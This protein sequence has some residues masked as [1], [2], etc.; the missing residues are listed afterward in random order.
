MKDL[1][2]IIRYTKSLWR[3][4]TIISFFVVVTALLGL[5]SPF[6]T[7]GIV[8][9]I[10]ANL[11]GQPAN[12]KVLIIFVLLMLAS[13]L[14][15]TVLS[16]INGYYGD[17]MSARINSL[18]SERY[19]KHLLDLPI[20]YYDNEL[21]GKITARLERSINTIANLMQA[22]A[23]NFSQTV[24]TV[25]F[26]LVVIAFYSW[27]VAILL[28]I[29]FPIYIWLTRK[30]SIVWQKQQK[31][32]NKDVDVANGRFIESVSQIR[33]VKSFA[34]ELRELKFFTGKRQSIEQKTK[35]QSKRWH[36]YDTARRTALSVI[37][38][39]IYGII[40]YQAYTKQISIGTMTL[41]IQLT[42]QAQFPLF[43]MSFLI[44]NLQRAIADS[45]DYFAVMAVEPEI[46]D[47]ANANHLQVKRGD[48]EYKNLDFSYKAGQKILTN[49][50]LNV[51]PG[52]KLALVGESG[53]G[54]TTIANL[55]LR[56]YEP[57]EGS[58]L[59]DGQD[60]SQVSQKSL[61]EAIGVV[62]QD[63]AL[64]SGTVRDNIVYSKPKASSD[65]MK[66]AA[67]AANAHDFIMKLPKGYDT[68]IGERG[69]KLSGGQKQRIA[70]AR[71]ILKNSPIL[72]LDE[73]TS[74]LDSKAERDV[75][76]ALDH[77]MEGRT[78]III[79][80]R[81]ST[82][83]AVDKIAAI[84]GGK[85]VEFGSPAELAHKPNGVY[86]ELL[87]LQSDANNRALL[88]KYQLAKN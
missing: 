55:L 12:V 86:A 72:I 48:I 87:Q 51:A 16:N 10:V 13:S 53:E 9:G 14:L 82:I 27:P 40:F 39:A 41:L 84:S 46:V 56:F 25:L 50:N 23:N 69:V 67:Q 47:I 24:L 15:T 59:I 58:I 6:L 88:S 33:V 26:T 71:A 54:K 49:I 19:Y 57:S 64:F 7:K 80:H 20:S 75:Q 81:L 85:I 18:L 11:T 76:E 79:A 66:Q 37:F 52:S 65:Q 60:I 5:V 2:K 31:G 77:L 4:Y 44:D 73:A 17:R 8:D 30:S 74:S 61:R 22:F 63:P 1:L 42:T 45:R 21:T 3:Y 34:T 43:G 68:E 38:F 83:A 35:V 78:T 36:W 29:L 70:I 32:I 28:A 62:F